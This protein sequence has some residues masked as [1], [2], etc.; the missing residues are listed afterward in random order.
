MILLGEFEVCLFDGRLVDR[1][2][3]SQHLVKV[4]FAPRGGR[5][6]SLSI[7]GRILRHS[8]GTKGSSLLLLWLECGRGE[9]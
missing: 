6:E 7:A 1:T 2:I 9:Q 4:A 5:K 3:D 8:K